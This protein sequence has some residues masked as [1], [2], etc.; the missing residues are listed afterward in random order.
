MTNTNFNSTRGVIETILVVLFFLGLVFAL[1]D[2]VKT[3]AGIFT[4]ALIF[5]VSFSTVFEK[6]VGWLK[7]RRKL[8]ACI[9]A[10]V[11]LAII[12]QPFLFLL[13]SLSHH[14]K[15]LV[16]FVDDV[17]Q[18]G[19][20]PLHPAIG[21]APLIGNSATDFYTH[22]QQQ[23][24]ETLAQHGPQIKAVLTGI[25]HKGAGIFGAA[26][27]II[28]GIIISAIFLQGGSKVLAPVS[29]ALKHILGGNDAEALLKTTG[30]AVRG[31]S[32]GIMGTAFIAAVFAWIGLLI[33]GIPFSLG[34]AALVFFLVIIQV[35]PLP[36]WI[37]LV[38]WL[39]LQ[40]HTGWGIFMLVWGV[41]LL[42]LD[43]LVKP[44]LIAKSGKLPF[45]VLFLGVIGGMVAWGFTGMFKGAII[46][47][48]F[49][50][51]FTKWL[52]RKEEDVLQ[53]NLA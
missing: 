52:E 38:L 49:Y 1:F 27:E 21:N 6:L 24:K 39:F 8:A 19:L 28:L 32:V 33:A 42:A 36:V 14:V 47:A 46:L 35:G 43:S 16:H 18:N 51:V 13:S 41:A 30:M 22:L 37:P 5:A 11:L 4:F 53:A 40:G 34:I 12:V 15:D 45:L 9:Y 25:L 23:P 31:V 44:L 7:G 29:N 3:F 10:F 20:P 2:V 26:I 50:T 17:K 48:V